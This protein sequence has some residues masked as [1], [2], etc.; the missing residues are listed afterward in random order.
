[1]SRID[2]VKVREALAA[3]PFHPLICI[4]AF[5]TTVSA[6]HLWDDSEDTIPALFRHSLPA[7]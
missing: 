4:P 2:L 6:A 7:L 5:G 3:N 1:M